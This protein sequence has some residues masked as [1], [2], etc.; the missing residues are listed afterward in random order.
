[1]RHRKKG[2]RLNKNNSHRKSMFRNMISSLIQHE[3]IKTT[4]PKA[5]ELKRII[6]PLIT[7]SKIDNVSNRRLIF[8]K[9]VNKISVSKLFNYI[10][11]RFKLQSGGY[12]RIIKC[13]FRKGDNAHMAYIELIN[14]KKLKY[15][16][17]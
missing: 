2:R 7:K 5:K 4:V 1:M 6:E 14:R 3:I 9:L 17:K 12:T 15:D 13:G 16:K 10:S 8:S 11:P